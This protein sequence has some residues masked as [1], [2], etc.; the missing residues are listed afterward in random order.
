MLQQKPNTQSH[1]KKMAKPITHT[2]I[3]TGKDAVN[4]YARMA[5]NK[6]KKVSIN[7]LVTIREEA[8]KLKSILK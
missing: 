3:L 4:F 6:D 2:P 8:K 1:T 7:Q 5:E